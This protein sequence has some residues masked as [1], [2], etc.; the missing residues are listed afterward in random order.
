MRALNSTRRTFLQSAGAAIAAGLARPAFPTDRLFSAIG[1]TS[2]IDRA[3]ELKALGA[4]F[5]VESVADFLVPFATDSEFAAFATKAK[6]AALPV[7][8]CNSFMRD[9]TLACVGPKADH[10]RV[11]EY[12]RIAFRRLAAIGGEFIVFGSNT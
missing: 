6:A 8:G 5:I 1:I 11:L 3:S 9:P 7:R 10:A 12:S 4:E 2:K